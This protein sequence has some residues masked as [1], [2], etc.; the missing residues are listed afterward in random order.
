MDANAPLPDEVDPTG[1]VDSD[2]EKDAVMAAVARSRP[3]PLEQHLYVSTHR[4]YAHI[5]MKEMLAQAL[6]GRGGPGGLFSINAA[7]TMTTGVVSSADTARKM[8]EI[9]TSLDGPDGAH[10]STNP[11]SQGTVGVGGG[12]VGAAAA[13]AA[14][15]RGTTVGMAGGT[16]SRKSSI[17]LAGPGAGPS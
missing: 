1:P 4:K 12:S 15:Q 17:V 10:R 2:E 3:R 11:A 6:A 5:R 13:A 14:G 9:A 8:S 16:A 7:A